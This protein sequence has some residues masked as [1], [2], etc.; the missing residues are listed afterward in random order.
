M[1]IAFVGIDGSGKS[2][3]A[4]KMIK[5]L[6]KMNIRC[7]YYHPYFEY[8]F[9]SKL[10]RVF[11]G[12][13]EA[14]RTRKNNITNKKSGLLKLWLILTL[15][16]NFVTYL[17]YLRKP[18]KDIALICD[19]YFFDNIVTFV[20]E[21]VCN[22][23]TGRLLLAF[24]PKPD[25]VFWFDAPPDIAFERKPEHS[26]L[27]YQKLRANY[28]QLLSSF[29]TQRIVIDAN[30]PISDISLIVLNH[31]VKFAGIYQSNS[32]SKDIKSFE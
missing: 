32:T 13:T 21:G 28:I 24:I 23:P 9:L 26:L 3:Q 8:I 27:V 1:L 4:Y 2:T 17:V 11:S 6:N 18:G 20:S 7:Q 12:A 19:R 29:M 22:L 5:A 30:Q 25:I 31:Y 16:D 15:F 10:F 14:L